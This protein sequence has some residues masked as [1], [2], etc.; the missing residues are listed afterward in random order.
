MI[1][2]R[3]GDCRDVL[4]EI[5]SDS[6]DMILTSPPYD[7]LR[8]YKNTCVWDIEV[9]KSIVPDLYRVLK[10]G[11][12]I[13]WVVADKT[14]NGS[15]SGTSFKQALYFMESGFNLH[16]TMIYKKLNHAPLTHNRYEQEF[17]YMFCFSKGKPK[18]FNPIKVQCKYGGTPH[19]GMLSFYKT[20]SDDLTVSGNKKVISETKIRGNVFEYRTGST[21]QSGKIKHPAMFPLKLA[22]DQIISWSNKD[23]TVL[24]MFM[25]SGTTGVACKELCRN[26][27]GIEKVEDYYEIAKERIKYTDDGNSHLF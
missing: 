18:T 1:D 25:G 23:D 8:D 27:I 21:T 19:W 26:F 22:R 10:D 16:D 7:N 12:V 3:L 20:S 6:I 9:F 2:L 13:V 5:E 14:E 15:E 11:G 17:E 4:K 24:D